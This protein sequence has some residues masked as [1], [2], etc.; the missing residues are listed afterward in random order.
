[1]SFADELV[2]AFEPWMTPDLEDFL[3][4]VG[5]MFHEVEWYSE[6]TDEYDG[7]TV[8]FSP[9]RTLGKDLPWLAQVMGDHPPVGL[10]EA[11]LRETV[12]D[13]INNHRGTL[14]AILRAAQR[15]LT[16]TRVVT[17]Q[18]RTSDLA[19]VGGNVDGFTIITYADQTPF[20]DRTLRDIL[21]AVPG[22]IILN[23]QVHDGQRWSSVKTSNATWNATKTKSW[24]DI[25]TLDAPTAGNSYTRPVPK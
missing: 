18:E 17:W 19:N 11:L 15:N 24:G 2:D 13:Q 4:S 9:D 23:Y 14:G 6:D 8:I 16:G 1:M 3:R 25:K 7:W 12:K 20:P 10:S 22:D 21:D 5:E